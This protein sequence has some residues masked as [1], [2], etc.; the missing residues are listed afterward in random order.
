[1]T[2]SVLAYF[3]DQLGPLASKW[4]KPISDQFS[5]FMVRML[6]NSIQ[7]LDFKEHRSSFSF[8]F[9]LNISFTT[10]VFLMLRRVLALLRLIIG[11][12]QRGKD[13][14][15]PASTWQREGQDTVFYLSTQLITFF[16]DLMLFCWLPLEPLHQHDNF[17]CQLKTELG[18]YTKISILDLLYYRSSK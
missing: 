7:P 11:G 5:I 1:M 17:P 4:H 10:G 16:A 8:F 13:K 18:R 3:Q 9:L 2:N 6:Q 12:G 15:G 14:A